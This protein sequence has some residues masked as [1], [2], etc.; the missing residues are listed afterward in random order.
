MK[1]E[2]KNKFSRDQFGPL[3]LILKII[4]IIRGFEKAVRKF[5][6]PQK[7]RLDN[8]PKKFLLEI[9]RKTGQL[10]RLKY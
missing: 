9:L 8:P 1:F 5:S 3:L 10:K 2:N 6:L 7:D 4:I